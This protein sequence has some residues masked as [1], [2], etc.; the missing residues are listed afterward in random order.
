MS[1]KLII[2]VGMPGAGKSICVNYLEKKGWPKVYFGGITLDELEKRKLDVNAENEKMVREEIRQNEGKDAYAKRIIE[3]INKLDSTGPVVVDGLY[4]WSEYKLFKNTYGDDAIIIAVVAPKAV[5]HKRLQTREIRPLTEQ[6]SENRDYA[7]IENLE[8]GGP[9]ANSGLLSCKFT[10][11]R[12]PNS[13]YR[14]FTSRIIY[15]NLNYFI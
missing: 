11:H 14:Q 10:R 8:K 4:S 3:Q 2:F 6:E 9:I 12:K 7:E 1:K 15:L 13:V 5:R